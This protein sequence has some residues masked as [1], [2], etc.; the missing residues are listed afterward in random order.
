MPNY[1]RDLKDREVDHEHHLK[2]DVNGGHYEEK[3]KHYKGTYYGDSITLVMRAGTNS[4]NSYWEGRCPECERYGH[5]KNETC[6]NCKCGETAV[7]PRGLEKFKTICPHEKCDLE[8]NEKTLQLHLA[9]EN[10]PN[11]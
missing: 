6:E 7:N 5:P 2:Y 8:F 10:L 1:S 11:H 3:V 9:T 4:Y